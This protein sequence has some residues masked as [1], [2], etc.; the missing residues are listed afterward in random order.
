[1]ELMISG[2]A[3]R[4][5][6]YGARYHADSG[7]LFKLGCNFIFHEICPRYSMKLSGD[8]FEQIKTEPWHVISNNV[9]F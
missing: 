9:A 3:I 5:E 1:M 7:Q 4:N 2:S 8:H 6:C